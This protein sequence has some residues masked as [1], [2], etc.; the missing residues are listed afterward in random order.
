MKRPSF[1]VNEPMRLDL[2]DR[3]I[4]IGFLRRIGEAY[5]Q[6]EKPIPLWLN[7]LNLVAAGRAAPSQLV[8]NL[9]YEPDDTF[10]DDLFTA[11]WEFLERHRARFYSLR[12]IA[13]Q[14]KPFS[15]EVAV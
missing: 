6:A 1:P 14:E 8:E 12:S 15:A 4:V 5:A 11:L 3:A 2:P 13:E 9:P 7:G 10:A